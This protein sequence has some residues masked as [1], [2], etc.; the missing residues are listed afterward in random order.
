M[1]TIELHDSALQTYL[2]KLHTRMSD[3]TPAMQDIAYAIEQNVRQRFETR[4]D[5]NGQQ[6]APWADSTRKTYPWHGKRNR[7]GPGREKILQR[8]GSMLDSLSSAGDKTTAVV[9]FGAPYAVYHEMGTRKMPRRGMLTANPAV[10]KLGEKD[11]RTA[12]D[13][14]K[15]YIEG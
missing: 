14:V 12:L 1:I 15:R 4:S 8:Y 13:I 6:W 10:G 7:Q 3:L 5:P 9:G 2:R 11:Q